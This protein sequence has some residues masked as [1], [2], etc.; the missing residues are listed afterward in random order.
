MSA[1]IPNKTEYVSKKFD[2]DL[3]KP[4]EEEERLLSGEVVDFVDMSGFCGAVSDMAFVALDNGDYGIFKSVEGEGRRLM[5]GV[6]DRYAA[7]YEAGLW[8]KK[9]RV[10]SLIDKYF[11]FG[12]VPPTVIREINGQ[13]GSFQKFV[14]NAPVGELVDKN[15]WQELNSRL[16]DMFLFDFIIWNNDRHEANFLVNKDA[17]SITAIDNGIS[18]IDTEPLMIIRPDIL[19]SKFV[20][21]WMYSRENLNP[22]P[23]FLSSLD[24]GLIDQLKVEQLGTA[25]ARYI[26]FDRAKSFIK[27]AL[28]VHEALGK[29]GGYIPAGYKIMPNYESIFIEKRP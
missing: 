11:G 5:N 8:H 23:S 22:S 13:T 29:L 28:S 18:F 15:H 21:K 19:K 14:D 4:T 9:E 1:E 27:R 12:L 10:V 24:F 3:E 16:T 6:L 25:V 26:G 20:K 17:G 2:L 7:R